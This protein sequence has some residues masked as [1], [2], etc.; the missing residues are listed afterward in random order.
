[1]EVTSFSDIQEE[2][3]ERVHRVVW[4]NVATVDSQQRPRSRILHPIWDGSTGWITT[5]PHSYKA[6]HLSQNPYVSLAYVADIAKPV[7]VDCKAE[8]VDDLDQ[9][10]LV[11][12]MCKDAPPPYGFDPAIAFQS[13][14]YPGFGLLKLTPWRIE[15]SNFPAPSRIWHQ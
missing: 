3:I 14:D 5:R 2:F 11:W 10:Q 4:C 1:L 15:L 7:Y 12:Q 13:F 8:W 6:K 9:K